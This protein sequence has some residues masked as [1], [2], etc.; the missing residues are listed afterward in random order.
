MVGWTPGQRRMLIDKLPDAAHL[1][2]GALCFGQFLSDRPFSASL[3]IGGLAAWAALFGWGLV[4][5]GD[6]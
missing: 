1:A 3:A 5:G 2:L 6:E 4:L